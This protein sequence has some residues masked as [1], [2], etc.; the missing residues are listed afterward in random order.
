MA[1][2]PAKADLMDA[3]WTRVAAPAMVEARRQSEASGQTEHLYTETRYPSAR[4]T[5]AVFVLSIPLFVALAVALWDVPYA[6]SETV[7]ILEDLERRS[8]AASQVLDIHGPFFRPLFWGTLLAIWEH[9]ATAASALAIYKVLHVATV[10][11]TAATFLFVLRPRVPVDAAA[12]VIAVAVLLGSP[13][14]RDNLENLPLNQMAIIGFISIVVWWLVSTPG[15]WHAPVA[16]LLTI[17]AIG[18]KEEGLIVGAVVV[19]AA[20]TG[21]PGVSRRMGLVMA[22]LCL[23]YVGIRLSNSAGWPIFMQRVGVGFRLLDTEQATRMFGD[24]PYAVYAYSVMATAANTLFSEPTSGVFRI[25]QSLIT[26]TADPW[27]INHLLSSLAATGLV[28]YWAVRV[29][30]GGTAARR[31]G[32]CSLSWSSRSRRRPVL[33]SITHATASTGSPSSSTPWRC[34]RPLAPSCHARGRCRSGGWPRWAWACSCCTGRGSF[35]LSA[36]CSTS[37]KPHR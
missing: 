30:G 10:L 13:A 31:S 15:R 20:W 33:D 25:T 22:G 27:Q 17:A 28:A 8:G 18:F 32:G 19:V 26:G 34:T 7:A 16:V 6:I 29:R 36:R 23:A 37:A 1:P 9:A 24:F 2:A 35:E 14:F 21:A 4:W 11:L 12:A 5:A 3:V